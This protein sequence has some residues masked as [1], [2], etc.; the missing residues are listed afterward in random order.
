MVEVVELVLGQGMESGFLAREMGQGVK[1]K[2]QDSSEACQPG[3][4]VSASISVQH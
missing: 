1:K 4:C 2:E 3:H